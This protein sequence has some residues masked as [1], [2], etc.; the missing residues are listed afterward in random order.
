MDSNNRTSSRRS[1]HSPSRC[2]QVFRPRFLPQASSSGSHRRARK[3][4]NSGSK[5]SAGYHATTTSGDV[6]SRRHLYEPSY[7]GSAHDL[8]VKKEESAV[9]SRSAT[10]S[11]RRRRKASECYEP[12]KIFDKGEDMAAMFETWCREEDKESYADAGEF[13][14]HEKGQ[15]PREDVLLKEEQEQGEEQEERTVRLIESPKSPSKDKKRSRT[16]SSTSECYVPTRIFDNDEDM[17]ATFNEWCEQE[18]NTDTAPAESGSAN[19]KSPLQKVAAKNE[20][21]HHEPEEE[22]DEVEVVSFK[23]SP[24]SPPPKSA[25]SSFK[26]NGQGYVPTRIFSNDQDR[27]Y[28]FERWCREEDSK[29]KSGESSP[30]KQDEDEVE[31]VGEVSGSPV[32]PVPSYFPSSKYSEGEYVGEYIRRVEDQ[33]EHRRKSPLEEVD[34]NDKMLGELTRMR[35]EMLLLPDDAVEY[36]DMRMSYERRLRALVDGQR[37][38]RRKRRKERSVEVVDLT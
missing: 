37:L 1:G 13:R 25:S 38:G 34:F 24:K 22:D 6:R 12:T 18:E 20:E 9:F 33:A 7:V 11:K 19:A 23:T 2:E 36:Y 16:R 10:G 17:E 4:S 21:S 27:S 29:H 32:S 5:K 30:E 28:F 14:N 15:P 8:A 3:R 31:I 26:S 35:R